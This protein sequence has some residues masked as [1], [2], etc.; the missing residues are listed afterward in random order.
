MSWETSTYVLGQQVGSAT[1]KLV[2]MGFA[3][4]A[5]KDGT[6]AFPSIPTIMEYAECS[7]STAQRHVAAL[8]EEGWMREGDQQLVAHYAANKR[9]VVYD[10]SMSATQRAEW[11]ML[12][13]AGGNEIRARA[14]AIGRRG[15]E[16]SAQVR[17]GVKTTPQNSVSTSQVSGGVKTTPQEEGLGGVIPEAFGVSPAPIGGVTHDTQTTHPTFPGTTP[18]TS[19]SAPLRDPDQE[20]TDWTQGATPNEVARTINRDDVTRVCEHLADRIA[21]NGSR[22]P[23]IT[24]AWREEARLLI[25]RDRRTEEQI[26]KAI[27]WC[28]NDTFWRANIRSMPKLREQYDALRLRAQAQ[29]REAGLRRG[30]D[31]VATWGER[32]QNAEG[33]TGMS[34]EEARLVF[35]SE[36]TTPPAH[37]TAG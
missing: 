28:Q 30:Y 14:E 17:R 18:T 26:H 25:D 3:N 1:R 27:D 20:K 16:A 23:T 6:A 7:R 8:V 29:A 24:V 37:G 35:G 5:H 19:S 33:I 11:R 9:P 21:E 22:R 12:H 4:H 36:P 13:A 32:P 2:L 31:D 15:G 10:L 34:A